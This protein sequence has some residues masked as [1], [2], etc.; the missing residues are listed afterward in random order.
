MA[1]NT[2]R[3]STAVVAREFIELYELP[4]S[5]SPHTFPGLT[6]DGH[7]EEDASQHFSLAILYIAPKMMYTK[8]AC[9][10]YDTI[11]CKEGDPYLSSKP[12]PKTAEMSSPDYSTEQA[13]GHGLRISFP[14]HGDH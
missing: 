6:F 4:S 3:S 12:R 7:I 2:Q 9:N 8:R 13:R 11:T 5:G 14:K 10:Y 1:F